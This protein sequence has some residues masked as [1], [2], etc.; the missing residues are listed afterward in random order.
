MQDVVTGTYVI[1]KIMKMCNTISP[2]NF[3]VSLKSGP[4]VFIIFYY[5]IY[6]CDRDCVMTMLDKQKF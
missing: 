4:E 5:H 2:Q 3:V 1:V 6:L